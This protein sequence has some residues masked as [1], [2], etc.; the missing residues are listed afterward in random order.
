MHYWQE[1]AGAKLVASNLCCSI[2]IWIIR[3]DYDGCIF[4]IVFK[5][6]KAFY[7]TFEDL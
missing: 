7:E 5:H 3:Q 2:V 6:I 1:L 4:F